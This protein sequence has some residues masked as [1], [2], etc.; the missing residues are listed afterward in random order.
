MPPSVSALCPLL[1]RPSGDGQAFASICIIRRAFDCTMPNYCWSHCLCP[2]LES[3]AAQCSL[4][5]VHVLMLPYESRKTPSPPSP[6]PLPPP[7][8]PPPP[9]PPPLPP[10]PSPTGG[11]GFDGRA[12]DIIVS[13]EL[14][15]RFALVSS[16]ARRDVHVRFLLQRRREQL[17][18]RVGNEHERCVASAPPTRLSRALLAFLRRG[19]ALS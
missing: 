17:E 8:S 18:H 12:F 5:P 14:R 1:K 9:S 15:G 13:P 19:A 4:L 7:P 6:P 2:P 10:P 3:L 16:P 11:D